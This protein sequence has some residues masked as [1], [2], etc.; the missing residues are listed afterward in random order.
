MKREKFINLLSNRVLFLDGAYGTEFV[1]RGFK[2][3]IFELL[4][5][6]NP[7]A[8]KDLQTLYINCNVDILLT[9]TFS[10][11][12]IKLKAFG[13]DKDI[14]K[15]NKKAVEI[16]KNVALNKAMVF[17]DIGP[18][19][20]LV[21]PFGEISFEEAYQVFKEQGKILIESGVDGIIL[22]T[23]LDLKE[24]KA[25]ILAIRDIE[26][27][28]P[29]IAQMTFTENAKTI[30]GSSVEIFANFINDMDVDVA[31]INCYLNPKD[32]LP[33]FTELSKFCNK[34]LSIEPNAGKPVV[35][36]NSIDYQTS[37][38]EFTIYSKD[39]IELGANMVGGCCGIGPN[40]I[41]YMVDNIGRRR[42]VEKQKQVN[43]YLSSRTLIKPVKPFL[44]VGERIN[45]GAKKKLQKQIIQNDFEQINYLAKKQ[46]EEGADCIDINLGIEKLLSKENVKKL[47]LN[48][49][50]YNSLPLSLDI[51]DIDLLETV[52][53]E[54]PA[55][56]LINSSVAKKKELLKHLNLIKKYGGML[57]VLCM[58]D[59]V[60]KTLN[61]KLRV[62][63]EA[64]EIIKESGISLERV[65]FD[66]LILPI[67]YGHD[68]KHTLKTIENLSKKGL[69]SIIGLSNLTYGIK[70]REE[71]NS[72]FLALALDKGL[73]SAICDTSNITTM[74]IVKGFLKLANR[75]KFNTSFCIED[76]ILK[77]IIN[78]DKE[79]LLNLIKEKLQEM[80]P[81]FIS[82]N[83]LAKAMQDI[84]KLYSEG[85]IFL[86]HLLLS[87][88][89]V[90]V[91]FDYL[92][93]LLIEKDK[94]KKGKILLATVEKD[95]HDIG[96]KIIGTV[97]SSFGYEV[98]DI[99]KDV[100]KDKIL[101][102]VLKINP[103]II[104][105]SAMMTTTVGYIKEVADFLKLN[106]IKIPIL[107]GGASMN[108]ELAKQ[109]NVYYAKDA[110]EASEIC[111]KICNKE[112]KNENN[113]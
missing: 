8:V 84:G 43:Q 11:N 61:Q 21:E 38:E 15:I 96:K 29:L 67:S 53:K 34:F 55:R 82:E 54:Y 110:I 4:N 71:V 58:K 39:Y 47:F 77:I 89:T 91:A 63:K 14:E 70:E 87:S 32:I 102:N 48:L 23:F 25:A 81:L 19:G 76:N 59:D 92:N 2:E 65:F 111:E 10:A 44:I 74:N 45:A 56:P 36:N 99:G 13:L 42:P 12:R 7:Q 60:T 109:F 51:Q 88:E 41:K 62:I 57:V 28:I 20:L 50:K 113:R 30:T 107:A 98:F 85:K 106:N 24:L 100:S 46:E 16:A 22:E 31:G 69:N 35:L 49:D 37:A 18:T 1:K 94:K 86:P 64:V 5:I 90:Q 26:E 3:D 108:P 27:D 72:T 79:S 33:V 105:L 78:G 112:E 6:K 73:N 93:N 83:I 9:N 104:G 66:P 68:F 103:D 52:L 97:L 17:G 40:H 80:T 95:I 75:E 101:K